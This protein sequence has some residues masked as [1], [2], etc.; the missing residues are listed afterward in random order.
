MML[1]ACSSP[2]SASSK[3]SASKVSASK[4]SASKV[5][6]SASVGVKTS[7][8]LCAPGRSLVSPS[9]CARPVSF[10]SRRSLRGYKPSLQ[11]LPLEV[12][13]SLSGGI[14]SGGLIAYNPSLV[15]TSIAADINLKPEDTQG[16]ISCIVAILGISYV[17]IDGKRQIAEIKEELETKYGFDTKGI[18]RIG[19]LKFLKKEFEKGDG[20]EKVAVEMVNCAR[21]EQAMAFG[22]TLDIVTWR[23]YWGERGVTFNTIADMD[24]VKQYVKTLKDKQDAKTRP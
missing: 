6:L 9:T 23:E 8:R 10:L 21:T 4:V 7:C 16:I 13:G 3:V 12:S 1:S 20:S 14:L 2:S 17:V 22:T 24:N 19:S 11:A 5:V 15:V 18:D